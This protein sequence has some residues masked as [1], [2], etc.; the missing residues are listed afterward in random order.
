MVWDDELD[1]VEVAPLGG[2][3]FF[4]LLRFGFDTEVSFLLSGDG[5]ECVTTSPPGDMMESFLSNDGDDSVAL[6][7]PC[8]MALR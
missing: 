4:T 6:L 3:Q 1:V 7:L 5:E 8:L 2:V